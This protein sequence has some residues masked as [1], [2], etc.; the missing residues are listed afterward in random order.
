MN[1]IA[2]HYSDA[3]V[4]YSGLSKTLGDLGH[5]FSLLEF[6][7]L[8]AVL[9][10]IVLHDRLVV[11]GSDSLISGPV[12]TQP[13]QQSAPSPQALPRVVRSPGMERWRSLVKPLVD[14]GVLVAAPRT[15]PG[16][17][18]PKPPDDA[19]ERGFNIRAHVSRGS[20]RMFARST[21]LDSWYEAGRLIGAEQELGCPPLALIR[22]RPFY[23]RGGQT[24]PR[25]TVCDLMGRYQ[26]LA[27]A[28]GELRSRTRLSMA[29]FLEVPVPPLPLIVLKLCSSYDDIVPRA[30]D[31]RED[32]AD[33]RASLRSLRSNLADDTLSPQKKLR[34]ISSWQRSWATLRSYGDGSSQVEFASNALDIPDL[35][36]AIEGD[37]FNAVSLSGLLKVVAQRGRRAF[38]SWRV[39]VLHRVARRYLATPDSE[40]GAQVERLFRTRVTPEQLRALHVHWGAPSGPNG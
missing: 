33:L 30:L 22:Q 26:D 8:C 7:D 14:A 17:A 27:S 16:N 36:S 9:E 12:E 28:L 6:L 40:L 1:Q 24:T 21:E 32:Y 37:A 39:R 25:H 3:L 18:G 34:A 15:R 13:S 31:I 29:S 10:G 19:G 5:S 11:V 38:Y 35:N 2:G 23:E 20:A 4:D